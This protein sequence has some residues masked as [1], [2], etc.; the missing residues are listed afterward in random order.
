MSTFWIIGG[1]RFGLQ[2][3]KSLRHKNSAS[4]ITVVEKQSAICR[5]IKQLD[6]ETVCMDGIRFLTT[7]L[8]HQD[9]PDWIVPAIPL[10]VAYEWIKSKLA[11]IYFLESLP[12]P[13]PLKF[14]LPNMI[15]GNMKQVYVSNAEFICPDKCPEPE[16]ICI[17]TGKP[18]PRQ[19]HAYL[20]SIQ[21]A[22]YKS[23][24]VRSRQLLPGVGG[25]APRD[26][27]EALEEIMT[28]HTSVLLSTA[29]RCHGVIN[30]FRI[31][32]KR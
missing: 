31:S 9:F 26:L 28:L 21:H 19:M 17:H 24:V 10:H 2:A 15:E 3:A 11:P 4:V 23:L 1:G 20:E 18:R 22:G 16:D 30:A 14:R 12:I 7:N 32:N 29:C 13:D 27:F 6:F 8:A 25:Y 5:R